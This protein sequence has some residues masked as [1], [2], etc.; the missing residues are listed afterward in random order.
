MCCRGH[1]I[2]AAE[3]VPDGFDPYGSTRDDRG[4]TPADPLRFD[5]LLFLTIRNR[6]GDAV[7]ANLSANRTIEDQ[8]SCIDVKCIFSDIA[9][10]LLLADIAHSV[11]FGCFADDFLLGLRI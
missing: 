2:S 7:R 8:T 11:G 6:L 10:L 9:A 5:E 3:L 1:Q 4:I